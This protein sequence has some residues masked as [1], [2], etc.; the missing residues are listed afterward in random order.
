M[1]TAALRQMILDGW[2]VMLVLLIMS[3][4]SITV[5][6]DRL[7]AFRAARTD[8]RA[9]VANVLRAIDSHGTDYAQKQCTRYPYPIA[10]VV[11][12]IL[13][14]PPV[15]EARVRA[16]QHATEEQI[17]VLE[18]YVPV[19]GTIAGTAPFVGLFGTVWGIIKA[20]LNIALTG[21]GG[22]QVV[23]AGISEALITTA[24]G[25]IVAVPAIITYNF[26]LR[27]LQR[28]GQEIELAVFDVYEK[29]EVAGEG[30]V[31]SERFRLQ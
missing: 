25:L 17:H 14:A 8:I 21:A 4:I 13:A 1:T 24:F 12:A 18:S 19:L 27:F 23:S 10:H 31:N 29:L 5:L 3:I 2:P 26:C 28:L 16:G 15:R 20:F 30:A 22:P 9:F 11:A 7:L 6:A